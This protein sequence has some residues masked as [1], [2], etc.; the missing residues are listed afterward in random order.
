MRRGRFFCEKSAMGDSGSRGDWSR[1]ADCF[2]PGPAGASPLYGFMQKGLAWRTDPRIRRTFAD[3]LRIPWQVPKALH[4]LSP[5]A[6]RRTPATEPA[7][8]GPGRDSSDFVVFRPNSFRF[9]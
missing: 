8:R 3:L 4:L 5:L 1:D 2:R 9:V 7:A 6:V